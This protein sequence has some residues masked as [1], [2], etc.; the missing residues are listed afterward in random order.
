[1]FPPF[2][3]ARGNDAALGQYEA[4]EGE[5][6]MDSDQN[7]ALLRMRVLT[8]ALGVRMDMILDDLCFKITSDYLASNDQGRCEALG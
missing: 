5:G 6:H 4:Q 8:E 1:M 2:S 3:P 7:A